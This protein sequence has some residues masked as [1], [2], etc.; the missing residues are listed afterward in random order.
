MHISFDAY[1]DVIVGLL[2]VLTAV[3]HIYSDP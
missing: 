3:Q 1:Y 2:H